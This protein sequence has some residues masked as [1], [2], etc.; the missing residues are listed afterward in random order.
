MRR[1]QLVFLSL[2]NGYN[3]LFQDFPS[4]KHVF[5]NAF[6]ASP[7]SPVRFRQQSSDPNHSLVP[8][9]KPSIPTLIHAYPPQPITTPF[10]DHPIPLSD[11]AIT[12]TQNISYVHCSPLIPVS[13]VSPNLTGKVYSQDGVLIKA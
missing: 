2:P 13:H 6:C 10:Q 8:A 4:K 1:A 7:T 12:S 11:L 5:Y 9:S 3:H